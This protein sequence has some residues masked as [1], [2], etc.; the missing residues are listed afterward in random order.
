MSEIIQFPGPQPEVGLPTTED[1]IDKLHSEAFRDLEGEIHDLGLI[2]EI[3]EPLI[4]SC[5]IG[6]EDSMRKLELAQFA[7]LQ[8]AKML[9]EFEANY[10]KRWHN[11]PVQP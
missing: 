2:G 5:T 8:L 7:V 6:K 11:E 9:K 4:M 1:D 3:A 10:R